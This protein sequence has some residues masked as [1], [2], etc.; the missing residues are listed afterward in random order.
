[1]TM[2]VTRRNQDPVRE[3]VGLRDTIS[4]LFDDFFSGRPMLA[5]RHP[6]TDLG[7]GWS[8]AVDVREND[9]EFVLYADL[10]GVEK[11]DVQL[12]MK[13]STLILSGKRKEV[14]VSD[15]G[16]LRRE[17]PSGAFYRAFALPADVAAAKVSANYKNGVL[18]IRLPKAEQAKPH[19]IEIA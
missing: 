10:P 16:W 5:T 6:Q 19:R 11:Q 17:T 14:E 7:L 4:G 3:M 15:E 8:P 2:E 18:E 9:E 13:D 1:M 12:E